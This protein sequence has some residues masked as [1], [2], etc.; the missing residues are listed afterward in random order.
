[1]LKD[2]DSDP[3]VVAEKLGAREFPRKL[4]GIG[5]AIRG[6]TTYKIVDNALW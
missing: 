5:A 1:M 6:D 2:I 4:E 3:L